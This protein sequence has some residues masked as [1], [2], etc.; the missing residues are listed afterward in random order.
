MAWLPI[1][2]KEDTQLW[3][4]IVFAVGVTLVIWLMYVQLFGMELP[5]GELFE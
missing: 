2:P 4:R 5:V 3:V 1:L